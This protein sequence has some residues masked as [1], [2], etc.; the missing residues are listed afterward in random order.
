MSFETA[1]ILVVFVIPAALGLFIKFW[2]W[3]TVERFW[4]HRRTAADSINDFLRNI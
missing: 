1:F 3:V 4:K 2:D